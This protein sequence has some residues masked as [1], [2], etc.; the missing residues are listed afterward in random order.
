MIDSD[1]EMIGAKNLPNAVGRLLGPADPAHPVPGRRAGE[2]A[3]D[4]TYRGAPP[5]GEPGGHGFEGWRGAE[6]PG[7]MTT[8]AGIPTERQ[9]LHVLLIENDPAD[10]ELVQAELRRAGFEIVADVVQE[11]REFE[12]KLDDESYDMVLADYNLPGWNG[13]EAL[14]GLRQRG[15]DVPFILVS[16]ALGEEVAVEC[17][18][19][20][21]WDYV[22]KDRLGRLP[23]AVRRALDEK[24]WIAGR[25]RA[26]REIR[27]LNEELERRVAERTAQLEAAN[28][29][30][31]L[32]IAE[33]ERAQAEQERLLRQAEAIE[34]RFR[35]L[36]ESAPDPIVIMN[37]GGRIVLVNRRTED[38]F[39]YQRDELLGKPVERLVPE[40]LR[41]RYREELSQYWSRPHKRLLGSSGAELFAQ[42]RD[43]SEFAVEIGLSPLE[44]QAETLAISIIHDVTR[45]KQSEEALRLEKEFSENLI[46]SSFEGILAFDRQYRYT[47]WN[48]GMERMSGLDK[49]QVL[50]QSALE[51][52]PFLGDS[53]GQL[54][55]SVLEGKS[56]TIRDRPYRAGGSDRDRYFEGS[57]SPMQGRQGEIVG[58]LAIIRDITER[59]AVEAMKD[60]FISVV[61]HELRTPLT[62]IRGA[63]GLLAGDRLAHAPQASR[64]MLEIAVANTDRLVRLIN[65]I[66]DLERMASGRVTMAK[67]SCDAGELMIQATELM[68][69]MAETAGVTLSVKPQTVE[70]WA[71]PDRILQTL[72]NL[73]SNA[74]KFSPPSSTVRLD[75]APENDE[76]IFR[77]EDQGRGIP[78]DKLES[79]FG[80]FQQVDAS[81]SRKGGTGLG[82]A[83]CRS[84]VRQHG[85]RIWVE[86][87]L[88]QGSQFFFTL[89]LRHETARPAADQTHG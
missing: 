44:S 29:D 45:R 48:P 36:L 61:S 51:V 8:S 12:A 72:T 56:A 52:F 40:R 77:V 19:Q 63:L 5:A 25:S 39:G 74:I 3:R 31:K 20:G 17:V 22:L 23:L 84:I 6:A 9:P 81:D 7:R 71:D 66:L 46:N 70:L 50:G 83:I 21:A 78:P 41:T 59:H 65:D 43:G 82:L 69:P 33:R 30:L 28:R 87:A 11:F 34:A 55:S 37:P 15:H 24:R 2:E 4:S 27:R 76:I 54:L 14:A 60:E 88:G 89:P 35:G 67:R 1:V 18:K 42:R 58:G 10:A 26:E 75:A 57:L 62:S 16:G 53:G 79:I 73:L 49:S 86:S 13:L 85:G 47:L 32:E 38:V 80:R 64:R 68:R